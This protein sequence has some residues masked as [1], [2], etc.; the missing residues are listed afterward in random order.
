MAEW[1]FAGWPGWLQAEWAFYWVV[2]CEARLVW[3][4]L[5]VVSQLVYAPSLGSF[6]FPWCTDVY[7]LCI[8]SHTPHDSSK[9]V[10]SSSR[11]Q[12]TVSVC[13]K[14]WRANR[15]IVSSH[16]CHIHKAPSACHLQLLSG[17][18]DVVSDTRTSSL[19]SLWNHW[20]TTPAPG[21]PIPVY[22]CCYDRFGLARPQGTWLFQSG[23][24]D[25]GESW[26]WCN[27]WCEFR[28]KHQSTNKGVISFS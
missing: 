15:P 1:A 5:V 17:V 4:A 28:L 6:S 12:E 26:S 22:F 23:S 20:C 2:F 3:L 7:S 19:W 14:T 9:E 8:G 18:S 25:G 27:G 10:Y 21:V 24:L 16:W 13:W 11:V